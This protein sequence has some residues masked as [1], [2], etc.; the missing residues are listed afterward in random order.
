MYIYKIVFLAQISDTCFEI[1]Q[2]TRASSF[3]GEI[4]PQLS[5]T[6]DDDDDDY[7]VV[8]DDDGVIDDDDDVDDGAVQ[9]F[10]LK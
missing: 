3:S 1:M 8:I 9:H 7:D 6:E 10:V 2:R 4:A 5:P